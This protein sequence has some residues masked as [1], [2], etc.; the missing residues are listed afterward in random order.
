MAER[1][2]SFQGKDLTDARCALAKVLTSSISKGALVKRLRS[3]ATLPKL[4]SSSSFISMPYRRSENGVIDVELD[5]VH[6]PSLP[7]EQEWED[8]VQ[9]RVL[10]TF[11]VVP[12]KTYHSTDGE[13]TLE[14]PEQIRVEETPK[15]EAST[16]VDK[17]QTETEEDPCSLHESRTESPLL[18]SDNSPQEALSSPPD[19]PG[20]DK[21]QDCQSSSS[22]DVGD[23]VERDEDDEL[24]VQAEEEELSNDSEINLKNED[25]HVQSP[26]LEPVEMDGDD[27][28]LYVKDED[29]KEEDE[30]CFPPPPPPVFF[31]EDE[32]IEEKEDAPNSSVQSSPASNGQIQTP[33][34]EFL[35]VP[36]TSWPYK[37]SAAQDSIAVA[38]SRFAQAVASA[39][40]RSRRKSSSSQA[41][42]GPH[43]T[44]PTSPRSIYQYGA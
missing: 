32:V 37:S 3:S 26:S 5:P 30:D 21:N 29:V 33:T 6:T 40:Q 38:P 11:K 35:N 20:L 10:T 4:H 7:T 13:I 12:S 22:S 8:P 39:V 36:S 17:A 18:G 2:P 1:L 31:D 28:S 34:G 16:E 19:L 14:V 42:S 43:S 27:W 9:R 24:E 44:L 23:T 15:D 25:E 41:P